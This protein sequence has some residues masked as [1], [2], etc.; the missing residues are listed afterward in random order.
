ML[1][2]PLETPQSYKK[3]KTTVDSVITFSEDIKKEMRDT[4]QDKCYYC[5][6]V[7]EYLP[8]DTTH[9]IAQTDHDVR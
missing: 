3:R 4:Y 2:T 8:L 9:V 6:A 7:Y 5:A 1:E